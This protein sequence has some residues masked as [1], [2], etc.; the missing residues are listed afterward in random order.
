MPSCSE[1]V[2]ELGESSRLFGRRVRPSS[3]LTG[4]FAKLPQQD[5]DLTA[6]AL[7]HRAEL[8]TL[9]NSHADPLDDDVDDLEAAISLH[10]APVCIDRRGVADPDDLATNTVLSPSGRDPVTFS[11]SPE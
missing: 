6:A 9:G 5:L 1:L 11:C 4:P 8:L 3:A 2:E 10:D 7:D